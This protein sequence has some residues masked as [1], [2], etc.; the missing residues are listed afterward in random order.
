MIERRLLL[1]GLPVTGVLATAAYAQGLPSTQTVLE[2]PSRVVSPKSYGAKGDGEADDTAALQA[3]LDDSAGRTLRLDSPRYKVTRTLWISGHRTRLD[4]QGAVLSFDGDGPALDFRPVNDRIYPVE[5]I[6]G[7]MA[8]HVN[9]GKLAIGMAIRA[10]HSS[11]EDIKIA[12]RAGA[13][14]AVGFD[15]V[16][17]EV[18]GTGPYYDTFKNCSVQSQGPGQTGVRF[19]SIAPNWRGPN[20]NMWIGGRI[21]QC[22]IGIA[23]AGCGNTFLSP[24]L[25][26]C[27]TAFM[28]DRAVENH[29]FGCYMEVCPTGLAFTSNTLGNG[30]VGAYGTGVARFVD[31]QGTRNWTFSDIVAGRLPLGVRFGKPSA[32][33]NVLDYY[34]EGEW[35]PSLAGSRIAGKFDVKTNTAKYVRVGRQ[36]TLSAR[37]SIKVLEPGSGIARFGG[38]PFSKAAETTMVGNALTTRISWP[39]DVTSV[40]TVAWSASDVDATFY[41][42]GHRN[43][44]PPFKLPVDDIADDCLVEFSMTYFTSG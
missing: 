13:A 5:T 16:G 25:E 1:H 11:F 18:F 33:P 39:R 12:L 35:T 43:A 38:L 19:S 24:T 7:H 37:M 6:I 20:A 2:G 41:L 22:D 29:V 31:D 4:G 17:D 28:F 21:G 26:G 44:S 27:K 40:V 9:R 3:A 14:G 15:L 36:V 8:I 42:A 34:G 32:D 10:S 30:L 23:V